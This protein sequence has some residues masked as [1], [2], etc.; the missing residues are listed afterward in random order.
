M[1]FKRVETYAFFKS[2]ISIVVRWCERQHAPQLLVSLS[3][4]FSMMDLKPPGS[5]SYCL[6]DILYSHP[7][8]HP[9]TCSCP[10]PT[11][12]NNSTRPSRLTAERPSTTRDR[13]CENQIS[14]FKKQQMDR[15]HVHRRTAQSNSPF[16]K[17]ELLVHLQ[18]SPA[19]ATPT[20]TRPLVCSRR[21]RI[22]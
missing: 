21:K 12:S 7:Q 8:L 4:S 9:S 2:S 13:R 22:G 17:K 18:R 15:T 20:K 1:Y 11:V 10:V 19:A 3:P 5:S 14:S 16:Y 6:S